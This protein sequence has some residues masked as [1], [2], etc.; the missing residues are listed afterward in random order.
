MG[1]V[2]R[3]VQ[4]PLRLLRQ[5]KQ[6]RAEVLVVHAPDDERVLHAG[7]N[8]HLDPR[9][10]DVAETTIPRLGR[11][12]TARPTRLQVRHRTI[13]EQPIEMLLSLL[14]RNRAP[15]KRGEDLPL[16]RPHPHR[17]NMKIPQRRKVLLRDRPA[18][19][20]LRP[21]HQLEH[22]EVRRS[23]R[24]HVVRPPHRRLPTTLPLATLRLRSK[25]SQRTMALLVQPV[26][27]L[28][29]LILVRL[30]QHRSLLR[31]QESTHRHLPIFCS[32]GVWEVS[33]S[34][35]PRL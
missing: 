25:R 8:V 24:T 14:L 5:A 17:R 13:I 23:P 6:P 11:L 31:G 4:V 29:R 9:A 12:H 35:A 28:V 18:L 3:L 26:P 33:L 21:R 34:H 22:H 30:H 27:Q 10:L 16:P 19:R 7:S 32:C 15:T 20:P 1:N 2:D